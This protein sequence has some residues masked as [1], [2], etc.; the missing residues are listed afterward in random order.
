M[1]S[2]DKGH[3]V[4]AEASGI[5]SDEMR[6]SLLKGSKGFCVNEFVDQ[7]GGVTVTSM[8]HG[9]QEGDLPTMT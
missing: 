7:L 3:L 1:L 4:P 8:S 6:E 5:D 9:E 2:F